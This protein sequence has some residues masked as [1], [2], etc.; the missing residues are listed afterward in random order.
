MAPQG[1][2]T[3]TAGSSGPGCIVIRGSKRLL[4]AEGIGELLKAFPVAVHEL[5]EPL[6]QGL[7]PRGKE[8]LEPALGLEPLRNGLLLVLGIVIDRPLAASTS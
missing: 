8:M 3:H 2:E 6:E 1:F 5:L 7:V 4:L